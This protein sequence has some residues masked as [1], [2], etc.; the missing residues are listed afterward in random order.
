MF[1]FIRVVVLLFKMNDLEAQAQELLR[2][3]EWVMAL[4]LFDTLLSQALVKNVPKERIVAY[5]LGRS[6]CFLEL[7]R[8]EAVV[9][10]CRKIIKL[11]DGVNG[12][13]GARAWRRLVH[14]LFTLQR[15]NEAEAAAAEW[16]ASMGGISNPEALKLLEHARV[17]LN[18]KRQ[19]RIEEELFR[20]EINE[21]NGPSLE[22]MKRK[23]NH[24][25]KLIEN[26]EPQ[27]Q[28]IEGNT[29]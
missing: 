27:Q 26:E 22:E 8:H 1:T 23:R 14:A 25:V 29:Y 9:S 10:D 15:F 2:H 12:H 28:Q 13:T 17:V 21:W 24:P 20:T 7:G 18:G 11:I 6:E 5:L 19:P 16:I 4:E 3:R